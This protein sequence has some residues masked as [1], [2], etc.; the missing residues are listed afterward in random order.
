MN[1][2]LPIELARFFAVV[3]QSYHLGFI[4]WTRTSK[5]R[6]KFIFINNE[7]EEPR[8]TYHLRLLT[9]VVRSLH[10]RPKR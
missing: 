7:K 4:I 1:Q 3:I 10:V 2:N 6:I 9:L 8:M 5:M